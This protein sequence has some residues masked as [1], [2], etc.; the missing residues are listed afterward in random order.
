MRKEIAD[1]WVDALRSGEFTPGVGYLDCDKKLDSL[2]V[3]VT[4]AMLLGVCDYNIV[5][6][7][8]AYDGELGRVP[9]SVKEWAGLYGQSGEIQGEFITLAGYTDLCGYTFTDIAD[10]IEENYERL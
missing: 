6:N 3:L 9:A 4:L 5:K 1:M 10:I 2:G 7:K 8:G